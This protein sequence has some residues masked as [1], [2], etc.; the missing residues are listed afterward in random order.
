MI[1]VEPVFRATSEVQKLVTELDAELAKS[2]SADQRHGLSLQALFEPDVRFFVALADGMAAGCGGFMLA[3]GYA[4]VKRMYTR[5]YLRRRGVAAAILGR[6]ERDAREAGFAEL[7]LE[8]G[9]FQPEAVR[10]YERH[11][12]ERCEIFGPYEA[13]PAHAIES[14]LFYSKQLSF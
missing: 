11:G 9:I 3:D 12:F 7:R 6:I 8:T 13:M 5:P 10:F 4:E 2:Y 14:S 1:A